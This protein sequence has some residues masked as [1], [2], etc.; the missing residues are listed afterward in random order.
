MRQLL[1]ICLNF[2]GSSA[3]KSLSFF[4]HSSKFI[5]GKFLTCYHVII[6]VEEEF[7]FN[8]LK[9]ENKEFKFKD[10]KLG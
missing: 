1:E 3:I 4:C 8:F 7:F 5:A 10:L 6:L 2:Q 9:M